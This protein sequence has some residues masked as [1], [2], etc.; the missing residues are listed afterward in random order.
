M[1]GVLAL[2][3]RQISFSLLVKGILQNQLKVSQQPSTV[4]E[5][6]DSGTAARTQEQSLREMHPASARPCRGHDFYA[7]PEP[8]VQMQGQSKEHEEVL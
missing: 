4:I 8:Q 5:Q 2:F 7:S 6:N 1:V 3:P